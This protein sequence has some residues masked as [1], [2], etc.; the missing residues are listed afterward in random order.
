MLTWFKF[1]HRRRT[2]FGELQDDCDAVLKSAFQAREQIGGAVNWAS[3]RCWQ[4][5]EWRDQDGA[6]GFRV[7]V[8]EASPHA[9]ELQSYVR[10]SLRERGWKNCEVVTEW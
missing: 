3:L 7:W 10:T 9:D 6:H 4:V 5:E 8:E 2:N 1:F